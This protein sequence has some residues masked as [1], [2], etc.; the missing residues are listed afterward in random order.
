MEKALDL[1]KQKF[2]RS[3]FSGKDLRN[4]P[5]HHSEFV[6]CNFDDANMTDVDASYSQFVA[7]TMRKTKCTRTNFAN[8]VLNILFE[9]SDAMGITLTL[10]CD[11]FKGMSV[12]KLWWFAWLYFAI[13]MKPES[14]NEQDPREAL[15]TVIG[16][17]RF[18]H[19]DN[20]FKRRQL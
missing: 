18:A 4:V 20:V 9:P 5:M 19:L 6:C 3:D 16:A 15:K 12:S 7:G 8:S 13:Q 14:E 2:F 17:E 11:T 1:S 10:N